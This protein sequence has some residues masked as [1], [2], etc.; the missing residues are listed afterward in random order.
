MKYLFCIFLLFSLV[1]TEL[2]AQTYKIGIVSDT[3]SQDKHI[4]LLKA[5]ISSVVGDEFDIEFPE[6][7]TFFNNSDIPTATKSLN[8][9]YSKEEVNLIIAY[10]EVSSGVMALRSEFDIPSI[11]MTILAPD[12]QGIENYNK[13]ISD[14]KNFTYITINDDIGKTI[15]SLKKVFPFKRLT[16]VLNRDV[17]PLFKIFTSELDIVRDSLGFNV[18]FYNQVND[19]LKDIIL[20]SESDAVL[21]GVKLRPSEAKDIIQDLELNKIP[22][23][24]FYYEDVEQHGALATTSA[25]KIEVLR[26]K[27]C[28]LDVAD[29][30]SGINASELNVYLD[31]TSGLSINMNTVRKMKLSP[32]YET[33]LTANLIDEE[34]NDQKKYSLKELIEIGIEN[35]PSL[36]VSKKNIDISEKD[37]NLSKSKYIPNAT[38]AT[39][40]SFNDEKISTYSRGA[41]QNLS[42]QGSLSQLIFSEQASAGVQVSQY[43]I[44]SGKETYRKDLYDLINNIAQLYFNILMAQSNFKILEQNRKLTEENLKLAKVRE[45]VGY[46]GMADV[47]QWEANLAKATYNMIDA[48]NKELAYKA[49]LNQILNTNVNNEIFVEDVNLS[50]STKLMGIAPLVKYIKDPKSLDILLEFLQVTAEINSPDLSVL[51]FNR[52]SQQRLKKSNY[53]QRYIPNFNA[54]ANI[55]RRLFESGKGSEIP[56]GFENLDNTWN[57]SISASLPVF[58]GMSIKYKDQKYKIELEQIEDQRAST[59]QDLK[60]MVKVNLQMLTVNYFNLDLSKRSSEAATNAFILIQNAYQQGQASYVDMLNAQN[61]AVSSR[62]D[63]ANAIFRFLYSMINLERTINRYSFFNSKEENILFVENFKEFY[64]SHL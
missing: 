55:N 47:Y 57:A 1:N 25:E 7:A 49:R 61:N 43:N 41:E 5:E 6:N 20:D 53:R 36:K 15:N 31:M 27:R 21:L 24:S 17:M 11:A 32:N 26:D 23:F 2:K 59:L 46:S 45:A 30:L 14:K 40:Q 19:N 10:G 37:F 54:S 9:L 52:A 13:G 34:D 29:I 50:D 38:L 4:R 3:P 56:T 39:K 58:Q 62:L 35:N 44:S 12:I 18:I 33:I 16:I 42:A 51:S 63:Q 8:I 60:S 22:V 48:Y 28:A 64:D